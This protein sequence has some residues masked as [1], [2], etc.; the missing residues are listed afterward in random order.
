MKEFDYEKL[1]ERTWDKEVLN[2]IGL[3]HEYKGRQQ[4]YLKQKS[5]ICFDY[6]FILIQHFSFK[7]RTI[8]SFFDSSS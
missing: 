6:H 1:A 2:Y 5:V 8:S 7:K 4:L 3:I